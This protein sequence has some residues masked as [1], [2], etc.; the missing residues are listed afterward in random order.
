MPRSGIESEGGGSIRFEAT[1]ES[2]VRVVLTDEVPIPNEALEDSIGSR[3]PRGAPQAGPSTFWLNRALQGVRARI[4]DAGDEP[5]ASGNATYLQVRGRNVE[6]RYDSPRRRLL[7]HDRRPGVH[8]MGRGLAS[9]GLGGVARGRQES[10][11]STGGTGFPAHDDVTDLLGHAAIRAVDDYASYRRERIT[12]GGPVRA[13]RLCGEDSGYRSCALRYAVITEAGTL[14]RSLT[15]IPFS[16]AQ[17]RTSA[18]LG[19][20]ANRAA[21][22]CFGFRASASAARAAGRGFLAADGFLLAAFFFAT[23]LLESS[24]APEATGPSVATTSR[25]PYKAPT[26]RIASSRDSLES[27]VSFT[28]LP[29]DTIGTRHST[30]DKGQR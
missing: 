10:P 9:T 1:D 28:S 24:S 4:A 8:P 26:T 12:P 29:F 17:E 5:F 22:R 27:T 7:R 3:P 2:L 11:S 25:T 19:E 14:P 6:A 20:P 15:V 16:R 23:G 21:V 30:A 13:R 18:V